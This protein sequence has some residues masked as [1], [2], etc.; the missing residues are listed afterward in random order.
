MWLYLDMGV[1]KEVIKIKWGIRVGLRSKRICTIKRRDN[2]KLILSFLHT[3]AC[4][5]E[6]PC[7]DI[8]RRWPLK[9]EKRALT[10][11]SLDLGLSILQNYEKIN[12]CCSATQP[13]VFCY[14]RLSRLVQIVIINCTKEWKIYQ[15]YNNCHHNNHLMTHCHRSLKC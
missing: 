11:W 7:E 10:C 15:S 4:I 12:F 5:Q 1:S 6:R 2:G 3:F 9:V 14:G 13:V 8:V